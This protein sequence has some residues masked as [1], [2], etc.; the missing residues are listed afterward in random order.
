MLLKNK[1]ESM[2]ICTQD[3]EKDQGKEDV[4]GSTETM[5]N[6]VTNVNI[7]KNIEE[8][9]GNNTKTKGLDDKIISKPMHKINL[10]IATKNPNN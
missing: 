7:N 8:E 10:K 2:I 6:T 1:D 9:V 5:T 3:K 4:I